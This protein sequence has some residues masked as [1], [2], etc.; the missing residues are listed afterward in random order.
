MQ[1]PETARQCNTHYFAVREVLDRAGDKWSVLVVLHLRD[2]RRRF[3]ELALW[4]GLYLRDPRLQALVPL[5]R[6]S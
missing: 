3:N 6:P 1:P 4:L 5:K 2:G